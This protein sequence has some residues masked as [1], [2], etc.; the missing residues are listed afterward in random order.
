MFKLY[1]DSRFRQDVGGA[2]S[3]S[4]F[5]IELPRPI[6]VSGR[7]FVDTFI[8]ANSFYTIRAGENDRVHIRENVST[9]RVCTIAEGQYNAITL[10]DALLVALQTGR[11]IGGD[12][13][14]IYDIPNNKLVVG[15]LDTVSAFH[16]YSTDYLKLNANIWNT[17]SFGSGGPTIDA[18]N[19]MSANTVLGFASGGI[20]S[21]NITTT[22]TGLD[23]V[24]VLPYHQLFLRSNLGSGNDTFGPDGS[25]DIIRRITCVVPINEMI[26]D[27]HGLPYDTVSCGS[28][29]I[30]SLRFTLTDVFGRNINTRGHAVSFSIIFVPD[31]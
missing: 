18:K 26:A 29:E 31:E 10:K 13:T 4:D 3:D 9:Y 14:V 12:Y 17:A 1:I 22:V 8:C 20:L 30:S 7:A 27:Q 19:L 15:T 5:A 2:N 21:G 6:N 28:R 24:N 11:S 23:V 25:S 16:I